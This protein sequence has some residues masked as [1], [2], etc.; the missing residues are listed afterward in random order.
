[1]PVFNDSSSRS[2]FFFPFYKQPPV[3]KLIKQDTC[4]CMMYMSQVYVYVFV[5]SW[6]NVVKSICKYWEEFS[7]C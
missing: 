4:L 6:A 7:E 2:D 1:M 3:E 5:Q